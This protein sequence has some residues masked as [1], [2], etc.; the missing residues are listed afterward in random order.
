M[1]TRQSTIFQKVPTSE[2]FES[3]TS[4]V[5]ESS[6]S[7]VLDKCWAPGTSWKKRTKTL[8]FINDESCEYRPKDCSSQLCSPP[9]MTEKE[10][11]DKTYMEQFMVFRRSYLLP[12]PKFL[13]K[14]PS[15]HCPGKGFYSTETCIDYFSNC[16]KIENIPFGRIVSI[17]TTYACPHDCDTPEQLLKIYQD[18]AN[19][20]TKSQKK[21]DHCDS[22]G[23]FS[24]RKTAYTIKCKCCGNIF[25]SRWVSCEMCEDVC[26]GYE[27]VQISKPVTSHCYPILCFCRQI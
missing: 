16:A 3:P 11:K 2:V 25:H 1:G 20:L 19:I 15:L 12:H 6:M 9:E 8:P 23:N 14:T 18:A 13:R 4:E 22:W 5:F 17:M 24:Y 10:I 27:I 7:D 26:N 21:S